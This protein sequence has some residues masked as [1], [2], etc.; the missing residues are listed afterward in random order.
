MWAGFPR[1]WNKLAEAD[2]RER[3]WKWSWR[4]LGRIS[5]QSTTEPIA[6]QIT[7]GTPFIQLLSPETL[8]L[9]KSSP[10]VAKSVKE[11]RSLQIL[12]EG[13]LEM[14]YTCI[15]P[16]KSENSDANVIKRPR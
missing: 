5:E 3:E 9:P 12:A 8:M 14:C 16:I 1:F 6:S 13:R 2:E 11:R 10:P 15:S 4:R 7:V